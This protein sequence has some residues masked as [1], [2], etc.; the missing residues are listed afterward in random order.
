MRD[1]IVSNSTKE[2][3]DFCINVTGTEDPQ[4]RLWVIT[5]IQ[6]MYNVPSSQLFLQLESEEWY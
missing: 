3:R 6:L 4:E 1:S 5:E 2:E